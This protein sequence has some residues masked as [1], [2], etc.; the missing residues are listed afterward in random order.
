MRPRDQNRSR[1]SLSDAA[2]RRGAAGAG[3]PATGRRRS[4]T[5]WL[6]CVVV[7]RT[8]KSTGSTC[9]R[10]SAARRKPAG[11]RSCLPRTAAGSPSTTSRRAAAR[12]SSGPRAAVFSLAQG[13]ETRKGLDGAEANYFV[14][15]LKRTIIPEKAGTYALGP[16]VVKGSFVSGMEGGSYIGRRLVA[17]APRRVGGSARSPAAAAADILRRNRQLPRGGVRSAPTALR[18]GDPLTLTLDIER[19]QV[20]RLARPD[21]GAEPRGQCQD[22]RRF[23]D[24]RQ[25][26]HRP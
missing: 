8:S 23:R 4:A 7:L 5:P 2:V 18:V 14:Y 11:W 3:S 20:E 12:F 10:A 25:E 24:H 13:R 17:V 6:R 21:L 1:E 15:E 19:G 22:R 9:R 16:A 26:P